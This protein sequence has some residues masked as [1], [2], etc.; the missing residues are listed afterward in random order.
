MEQNYKKYKLQKMM[1]E[2]LGR[3]DEEIKEVL[4][5]Y[6][7]KGI[8]KNVKIDLQLTLHYFDYNIAKILI[9]FRKKYTFKNLYIKDFIP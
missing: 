4:D 6:L 5:L 2:I 1:I 7:L 9:P 8:S 3:N